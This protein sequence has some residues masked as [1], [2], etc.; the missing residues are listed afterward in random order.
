MVTN[1]SILGV[2]GLVA[3]ALA[4]AGCDRDPAAPPSGADA[5]RPDAS[6]QAAAHERPER[7]ARRFARA[8]RNPAFRAYVWAQLDASPVREHKLELRRFLRANGSRALQVVAGENDERDADVAADADS[9]L[10]LELYLPVPA[11]RA[12][13]SG[14]ENVLVATALEDG[15]APVAFDLQGRRVPLSADAPPAIPVIALVPVETDFDAL[16]VAGLTCWEC[17]PVPPPPPPPPA[18]GPGAGLYMTAAQ[19]GHD[20]E[21]WL[22]GSPEFEV[23]VMG[24]IGSS[25]SMTSYQC[26]G[27]HAGGPYAYDQNGTAWSGNV[28][29]FSQTQLNVYKAAHPGQ[30]VRLMY[31]EDDDGACQLRFDGA[32]VARAIEYVDVIYNGL[33]GGR[34]SSLVGTGLRYYKAAKAAF[35][36]LRMA[37][38]IFQTKDEYIGI[39]VEDA[40]VGQAYPGYNW[41]VKGPN[42]VT[43][44]WVNLAPCR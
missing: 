3:A 6:I 26:A 9:G 38:N 27:E 12:A 11:H 4:A 31:L 24:Q 40:I 33:A 42:N 21:G 15:E 13:W 32:D 8:L 29:L 37:I 28:L 23:H 44:G 30:G 22:K 7:L 20:Y 16:P 10:A 36:L 14:G 41:F 1:R 18:P 34:D 17:D 19:F 43:N 35:D 5:P 39:A 25:D 2:A